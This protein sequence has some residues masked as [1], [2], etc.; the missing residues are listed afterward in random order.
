MGYVEAYFVSAALLLLSFTTVSGCT[1]KESRE[2]CPKYLNLNL[3]SGDEA[4][5]GNVWLLGWN[6]GE[7]F[8]YTIDA[9]DLA[10]YWVKAVQEGAFDISV[11]SGVS[12]SRPREKFISVP[13]GF[14]SDSL[15]AYYTHVDIK[16]A[17]V[18]ENVEFHKQFCTVNLDI[19]RS[20]EQMQDYRFIVRGNTCG[21]DLFS[22]T[23]VEGE[24]RY[25]PEVFEGEDKVSFRILRQV[26]DSMSLEILHRE[27][28]TKAVGYTYRSLGLFPLG[29]YIVRTGYD[30]RSTDLSDVYVKFGFTLNYIQIGVEGWEEGMVFTFI[31]Q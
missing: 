9:E 15:Y 25:E 10:S 20:A 26:D 2:V 21:F 6:D 16:D 29:K 22:F 5:N 30:W 12:R 14:Q 23:P 7:V 17:D 3:P 4:L 27:P 8:R 28:E 19:S 1:V 18:I 13:S 11:C 31:E 24:Y